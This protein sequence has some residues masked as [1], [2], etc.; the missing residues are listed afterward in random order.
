MVLMYVPSRSS[1]STSLLLQNGTM[2]TVLLHPPPTMDWMPRQHLTH[3]T[4]CDMLGG[5]LGWIAG[6]LQLDFMDAVGLHVH[7]QKKGCNLCMLYN[8]L[9]AQ[10][11]GCCR[12]GQQ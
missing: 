9:L 1:G 10:W 12:P 5:R 4:P 2:H 7:A 6:R 11:T 8:L 3:W